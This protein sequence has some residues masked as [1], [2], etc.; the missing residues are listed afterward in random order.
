MLMIAFIIL[1][2]SGPPV[3]Y[4]SERMKTLEV[5]FT[6][7]K[8]RTMKPVLGDNGVSG[9][10]KT[11]RITGIGK[12]LR[13]TRL[14]EIPQLINILKG[15]ISFVGPRPPLREYLEKEKEIYSKVLTVKPGDTGLASLIYHRHEERILSNSKNSKNTDYLYI[16]RCIP[17]KAKLDQIYIKN[18]SICYDIKIIILTIIKMFKK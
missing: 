2:K 11:S 15:D 10:H 8:F 7:I 3:F 13:K 9:S 17:R 18:K 12:Y 14:D 4:F 1:L 6:L 5:S 16:K